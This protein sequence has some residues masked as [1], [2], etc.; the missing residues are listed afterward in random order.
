VRRRR[1]ARSGLPAPNASHELRTPLDG[2]S[3]ASSK[4]CAGPA[5]DDK[6]SW[7]R[8]LDIMAGESERMSRLIAPTLLFCRCHGIEFSDISRRC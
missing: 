4:R 5:K 8:F 2:P 6:A 7:D 3:R 1:R